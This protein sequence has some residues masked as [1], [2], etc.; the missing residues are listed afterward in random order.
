MSHRMPSLRRPTIDYANER[1]IIEKQTRIFLFSVIIRHITLRPYSATIDA[2][3]GNRF[4]PRVARA[5]G[6]VDM[7]GRLGSAAGTALMCR[8]RLSSVA[9]YAL[10]AFIAWH[11]HRRYQAHTAVVA[12][13]ATLIIIS[14][15]IIADDFAIADIV[16][17][18]IFTGQTSAPGVP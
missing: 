7:I 8:R 18:A 9:R 12:D 3:S 5:L 10:S 11:V 13:V 2:A 1:D 17:D 4:H 15:R 14:A 16:N 6:Q